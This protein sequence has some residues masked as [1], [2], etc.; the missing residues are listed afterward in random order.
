MELSVYEEYGYE[1]RREYLEEL[2]DEYACPIETV[3]EVAAILGEEEDF[4]GLVSAMKD[5]EATNCN[6]ED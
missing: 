5:Y 4:D 2:E 1:S 3:L 6:S